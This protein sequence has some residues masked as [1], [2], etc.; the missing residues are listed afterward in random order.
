MEDKSVCKQCYFLTE[1]IMATTANKEINCGSVMK[2]LMALTGGKGGGTREK[3]GGRISGSI[4][5]FLDKLKEVS[6]I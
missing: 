5:S 1:K 3:A 4:D 6:Y 2:E